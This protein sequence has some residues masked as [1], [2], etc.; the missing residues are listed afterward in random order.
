MFPVVKPGSHLPAMVSA[1]VPELVSTCTVGGIMKAPM[2][3]ISQ[4]SSPATLRL[5]G[6]ADHCRKL[7]TR[8]KTDFQQRTHPET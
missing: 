3:C 1:M 2:Q 4:E 7:K 8:L 6:T 5:C